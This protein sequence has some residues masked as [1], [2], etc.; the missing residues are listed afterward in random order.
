MFLEKTTT[1]Q[2]QQENKKSNGF[3]DSNCYPTISPEEVLDLIDR[4]SE[5]ILSTPFFGAENKSISE[6]YDEDFLQEEITP[7]SRKS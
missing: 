1:L 3:V 7:L 6:H 5:K 4:A 2:K